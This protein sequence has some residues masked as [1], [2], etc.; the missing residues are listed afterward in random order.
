MCGY[1]SIIRMELFSVFIVAIMWSLF[2]YVKA[3]CKMQWQAYYIL[4]EVLIAGELQES[5]KKTIARLIAAQV[6]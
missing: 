5:S 1:T 2:L 3:V 6:Q 4:D